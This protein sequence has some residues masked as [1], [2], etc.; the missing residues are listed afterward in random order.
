[1]ESITDVDQEKAPKPTN[2]K[3]RI[4]AHKK[5][6]KTLLPLEQQKAEVQEKIKKARKE[7]SADTGVTLATF[8][9]ARRLATIEDDDDRTEKLEDLVEVFNSL[10]PGETL[11]FLQS[12]HYEGDAP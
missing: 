1:M 5:L 6:V 2:S 11:N 7:W 9:A 10:A 8:D 3:A 12:K 4:A